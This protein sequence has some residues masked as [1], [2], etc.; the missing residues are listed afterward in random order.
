MQQ[1]GLSEELVVSVDR[2]RAGFNE[3][4]VLR[5]TDLIR[6]QPCPHCGSTAQ[7]LNGTV[8]GSVISMIVLSNYEKRV[9]IGCVDCLDNK[10]DSAN[11]RTAGLGWWGFP[12]GIIRTIQCFI[13][14]SR[15]KR[16]H[17]SAEPSGSLMA[18]VIENMGRIDA[19][20]NDPS[21]LKDILDIRY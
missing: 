8:A 21:R 19:H 1:R 7:P 13:F 12:W 20:Q 18:F 16:E 10:I 17:R 15:M 4:T 6:Q 3:A 11:T 5:F 14:N 9:F 2:Q